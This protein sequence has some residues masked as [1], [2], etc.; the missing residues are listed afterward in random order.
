M[1]EA[2]CDNRKKRYWYNGYV[3]PLIPVLETR[4]ANDYN[5][6]WFCFQ[7]MI[8]K[9]WSRDSVGIEFAFVLDSH[10]GI[11]VTMLLPYLRVIICIPCPY[12][13]MLWSQKNLWRRPKKT[14][15]Q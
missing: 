5:T 3:F 12:R 1:T 2:V 7:W 4:P 15:N 10:W 14:H 9:I 6:S 11:G 13:L 8:F